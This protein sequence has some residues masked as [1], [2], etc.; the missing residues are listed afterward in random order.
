[1]E[2]VLQIKNIVI[3]FIKEHKKIALR[4]L[5]CLIVIITVIVITSVFKKEK[6]GN[7]AGNLIQNKGLSVAVGKWI[8]YV[9]FDD[10]EPSGIYKVKNNGEKTEKIKSG[11]FEYLNVIDKYIYCLE[12]D[13][14]KNQYNLVKMKTNG[15]KKETIA[16]NIDHSPITA[17]KGKIYYFKDGSL[18]S[19]KDNGSKSKKISDKKISYYEIDGNTMYYIYENE[20][21]S[22][23][24][25]M[26]LN[27]KNDNIRI[28][29]LEDAEYVALHVKGNKIYYIVKENE[30]SYKL[31][32]MKKNGE[33]EERIYS[34]TEKISNINMQDDAIYYVENDNGYKI[35]TINYKAGNKGT[36]KKLDEE[37]DFTIANKWVVY[38]TKNKDNE[39]IVERITVKGEKEQSL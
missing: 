23:I 11:Y 19:I 39:V 24:A 37:V 16:R 2:R 33:K 30:K 4:L 31:Y 7:S 17:I 10:G 13:E 34:F 29:K 21:S 25:K 1:M 35:S 3:N 14:E 18:Y 27:G 9:E 12:K 26:K 5:A 32:K 28:G 22:Y 15:N 6:N 20:G 36:I 38:V 8:Y